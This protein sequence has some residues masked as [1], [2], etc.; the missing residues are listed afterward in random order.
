MFQPE[1]V[2][3]FLYCPTKSCAPS[4]QLCGSLPR[5]GATKSILGNVAP[6]FRWALQIHPLARLKA[7]ST[8]PARQLV[9]THEPC[10]EHDLLQK[11]AHRS[12][13]RPEGQRTSFRKEPKCP[14]LP[15]E[16]L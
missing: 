13:V 16:I 6:T 8:I 9:Q 4:E 2:C 10:E 1:K 11:P 7:G 12:A 15:Q 3:Y 5:V 14:A